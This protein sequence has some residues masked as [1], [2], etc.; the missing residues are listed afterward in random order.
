MAPNKKREHPDPDW[1]LFKQSVFG[2]CCGVCGKP[3]TEVGQL[4]KGHIHRHAKGGYHDW[5]NR[6]PICEG[7]NEKHR[8]RETQPHCRPDDWLERFTMAWLHRNRPKLLCYTTEFACYLIPGTQAAQ[9]KQIIVWDAANLERL[10]IPFTQLGRPTLDEAKTL[11][12]E[13]IN[14]AKWGAKGLPGPGATT[15]EDM[16]EKAQQGAEAFRRAGAAFL[17]RAPW[18][19]F[20]HTPIIWHIWQR[21]FVD[22]FDFYEELPRKEQRAEA[23]T[24]QSRVEA[25]IEHQR[26]TRL[27]N[28]RQYLQVATVPDWPTMTNTDREFIAT[29]K[30]LVGQP[31]RDVSGADL[32]MAKSI[33]NR[34][35]GYEF[36]RKRTMRIEA[37]KTG[38]FYMKVLKV[39]D[40]TDVSEYRERIKSIND[41][42]VRMETER[43]FERLTRYWQELGAEI[44]YLLDSQELARAGI[45]E[46]DAV[47]GDIPW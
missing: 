35:Q 29:A 42:G 45:D 6:L 38:E 13:L 39:L 22:N 12:R 37:L 26:E 15:Q 9:N 2:D 17:R 10:H 8:K 27:E 7:C 3:E 20:E 34:R 18:A 4:Q 30:G 33:G 16:V 21:E 25:E 28:W 36:E 24:A 1:L 5:D 11:V 43:D 46:T 41:F 31:V 14:V 44:E 47:N 23:A 19:G 40:R 32:E